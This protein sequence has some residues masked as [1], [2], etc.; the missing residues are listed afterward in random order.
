MAGILLGR[1]GLNKGEGKRL[2]WEMGSE[3]AAY[4]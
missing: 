4:L 1:G 3:R 2:G